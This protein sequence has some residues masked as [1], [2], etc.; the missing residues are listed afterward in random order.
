MHRQFA[1]QI[2]LYVTITTKL[3]DNLGMKIVPIMP[4]YVEVQ[5][6]QG[7]EETIR[8][9]CSLSHCLIDYMKT[10]HNVLKKFKV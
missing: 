1:K 7:I 6:I 8:T 9:K 10:S 5:Q 2:L 4:I 3:L